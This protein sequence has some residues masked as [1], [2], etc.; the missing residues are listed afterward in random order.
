MGRFDNEKNIVNDIRMIPRSHIEL[1]TNS[2]F[3]K[4]LY[5]AIMR[6][7]REWT[8][9][10]SHASEPPDFFSQ[11]HR[12]MFD[13]MRVN[14]SETIV[15]T[16][17]GKKVCDNPVLKRE[18]KLVRE[19]KK[20]FPNMPE[21]NIFINAVP[22]GDYDQI[23]NYQNYYKHTQKVLSSHVERI[24][25]CREL[26][27]GFKMGFLIMDETESYL[28]HTNIMDAVTPYDPNR[29]Y[30]ILALPHI[31]YIDRRFMQC[32]CGSGLDFIIW[33]MPYKYNEKMGIQLPLLCFVDMRGN[34]IQKY[35]QDYPQYLM[36]RM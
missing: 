26:H 34:R 18:Q 33:Y 13:A 23:H 5:N 1:V 2:K 6:D 16:K 35:L 11:N 30:K 19:V 29:T 14:D 21:D 28:Q 27:P 20:C 10:N 4:T 25:R 8:V 12:I 7:W 17:R 24:S 3:E 31:P 9:N 22:E 36:R 15:T 32:L